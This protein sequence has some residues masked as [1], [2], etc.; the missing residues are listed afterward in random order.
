MIG[1]NYHFIPSRTP[2]F[3]LTSEQPGGIVTYK[4]KLFGIVAV[5]SSICG[6][7]SVR[8]ISI[9]VM[10][11]KTPKYGSK[12]TT[13]DPTDNWFNSGFLY[14][15]GLTYYGFDSTIYSQLNNGWTQNSISTTASNFVDGHTKHKIWVQLSDT[16]NKLPGWR[17][18][19]SYTQQPTNV[20][21]VDIGAS[22]HGARQN[23][24][25]SLGHMCA[26]RFSPIDE[27]DTTGFWYVP[28]LY[29][30]S[31]E[32]ANIT[33]INN[34]F[35]QANNLYNSGVSQVMR[36]R[37]DQYEGYMS[38]DYNN[39]YQGGWGGALTKYSVYNN[40]YTNRTGYSSATVDYNSVQAWCKLIKE[41]GKWIL[42]P[43]YHID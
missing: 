12:V 25:Y 6:E 36:L 17:T 30:L 28:S 20:A 15:S 26:W 1:E 31:Y 35:S 14:R 37:T 18:V 7:N 39:N 40:G 23:Q 2:V 27:I 11:I 34:G 8:I 43:S 22:A 13:Q 29:E 41:N 19:E 16:N 4:N 38:N 24:G 5:P 42:D 32:K 33:A 21:G 9:P 3:S 10:S